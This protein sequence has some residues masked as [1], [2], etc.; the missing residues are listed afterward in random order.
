VVATPGHTPGHVAIRAARG[1][2]TGV[3]LGDVVHNPIQMAEPGLNSSF[4][5]DGPRARLTRRKL[6]DEAAEE[7]QLLIPGHFCAPH[8]GRVKRAGDGFVFCGGLK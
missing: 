3:F 2:D 5:E 6:L 8:V 4:C 7:N 1:G